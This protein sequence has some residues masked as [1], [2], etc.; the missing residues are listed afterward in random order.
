M[1]RFLLIAA[2]FAVAACSGNVF[3]AREFAEPG[4]KWRPIPLWFW[5]DDAVDGDIMEEQLEHMVNDDFYGGCA[6]LPFGKGFQP[7]YLSEE[8]F[9]LYS[10]AVEKATALGARMSIY[11][12]YGFPSGSM[13]AI[14]GSGVQTFKNNHPDHTIKRLVKQEY[15]VSGPLN[16]IQAIPV[17]G[18]LMSL[19]AMNDSTKQVV[20]L[21]GCLEGNTLEWE[22]PAGTWTIMAFNCIK[23]RD[24]NVDYLSREAV[25]LFIQDT[26]E[27]Y[28]K[29][30]GKAFG[31]TIVSTFFD[32]PTLY[33]ANGQIWTGDFNEQ[34]EKRYGFS[35]ELLYPAL[36]YDIGPGTAAA[37]NLLFG[38]RSELYSEGFMGAI[39]SWAEKHRII[40]T[41]HQDQEE[42]ANPTGV[43]GDLMKDGRNI[44]MPGIDKIG[45]RPGTEDYYKVVSSSAYNWDKSFVMSETYG[46]YG[47]IPVD[48][49]YKIAV[50]QYSKGINHLIPHAVWYNDDKV[51][52]KP[53]LSWRNPLYNKELPAFN[54]FLSRLN[55]M[56]AR[57]G[58]H[59]AD[60]AVLYPIQTL[61]AGHHFDGPLGWYRGGVEIPGTDYPVIS[62]LLTDE[63]G[64]DF[65]Y[66]H[67]EVMDDRCIIEDGRLVM[68]N[69]VNTERF[70]T[71]ILPGVKTISKSNLELIE[72]AWENGVAIVF[73]TQLPS[74]SADL[75]G[76][77]AEV[78][79]TVKKI[80]AGC[81]DG[82]YAAFVEKPD[83]ETLKQALAPVLTH[84][85]VRFEGSGRPFNY[86]H[87]VIKGKNIWYFANPGSEPVNHTVCLRTQLKHASLMDPRTGTAAKA[88]LNDNTGSGISFFLKLN[89]GES[90][91]LVE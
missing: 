12:E 24:P 79:E 44:Q 3:S 58:R 11:D 6:I 65:T 14:N 36:W 59:V 38:L 89:P 32:E 25:E 18:K 77:D 8:Y 37:R 91:F 64:A 41:G 67:P 21:G 10:K 85:D 73:T 29:R 20:S 22:V 17:E 16:L 31:K 66:I 45:I 70:N 88:E 82:R 50:E 74:E 48:S 40:A 56:L 5:N 75:D 80:L 53:E 9:D 71:I 47:N 76:N 52:F 27:Q 42:V 43:A 86:I 4:M 84:A 83:A 46:A 81:Q 62:R 60:I 39:G 1:R 54:R 55:Y 69:R 13:G 61:Y 49:L 19:V 26:H 51:V 28:Y 63:I 34:F 35:P 68:K 23:D 2:C 30:F 57:P 87:R 72:R 33:R 15:T 7:G 90:V 78:R